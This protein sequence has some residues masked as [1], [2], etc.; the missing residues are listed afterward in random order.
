M[1]MAWRDF[2]SSVIPSSQSPKVLRTWFLCRT[3]PLQ[4]VSLRLLGRV[5]CERR[6]VKS[7]KQA[8]LGSVHFVRV[9]PFCGFPNSPSYLKRSSRSCLQRSLKPGILSQNL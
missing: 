7:S 8:D 6:K 4:K 2:E 3:V 1:S 5:R 9:G